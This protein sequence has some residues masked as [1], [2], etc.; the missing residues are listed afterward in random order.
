MNL[1]SAVFS[2]SIHRFAKNIST[3]G[4]LF[5]IFFVEKQLEKGWKL[6]NGSNTETITDVLDSWFCKRL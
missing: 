4:D 5:V 2:A 1:R 3:I 6:G